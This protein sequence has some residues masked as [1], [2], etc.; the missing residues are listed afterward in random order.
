MPFFD[1]DPLLETMLDAAPGISDPALRLENEQR[2]LLRQVLA[3]IAGYQRAEL[4]SGLRQLRV[5]L[6]DIPEQ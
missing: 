5:L 6:M 1:L 4:P 2:R 3:D